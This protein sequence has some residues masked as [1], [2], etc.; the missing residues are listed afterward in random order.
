MRTLACALPALLATAV[1]AADGLPELNPVRPPARLAQLTG[2]IIVKLRAEARSGG[3]TAR[4][5]QQRLAAVVMRAGVR[6]AEARVI[7]ARLH[8]MQPADGSLQEILARL[9]A[10][11]EVEYAEAEQRRYPHGV[12]QAA[13]PDDPLYATLQWYLQSPTGSTPAAIDAAGGWN[14]STG[15]SDLVIADIDTGVRYDHPDLLDAAAGGRLL[16]GYCFISD[17][18]VSNGGGC[19][20]GEVSEEE[21]SDP[22]DWVTEADL[23]Q[24]QCA[25]AKA[26]NSS[27][28]GTRT[29]SLLGALTNNGLGIAGVTW[30][31]QILPVRALGRCGGSDA[32]IASA[33]LW[34]GGIS[35]TGAPPNPYPAKIINMSL[36]AAGVCPQVYQDVLAQLAAHGVLVVASAGNGGAAVEAPASCPG[37]AAVAGLRHAGTKTGYSNLG[38]EVIISAPSGNC[39]TGV[40]SAQTPCQ[41]PISSATNAGTTTPAPYTGVSADGV[42]TDRISSLNLGTSFA[43]PLVAGIGALMAA[44]NPQLS[45]CRLIARLQEG[46]APFPQ[47]SGPL[48]ACGTPG[49]AAPR[50]ECACTPT[51]CGAGMVSAPGALRAAL[52]PAAVIDAPSGY[53]SGQVIKLSGTASIA[54]HG[55]TLIAHAWSQVS[56]TPLQLQGAAS[57]A[58]TVRVPG[59]GLPVLRLSVTDSDGAVDSAEVTIGPGAVTVLPPAAPAPS[60]ACTARAQIG[61]CPAQ[62]S[63]QAG[64]GQV[65]FTADVAGASDTAVTWEVNGM[66]GGSAMAG[67]ISSLG[68][69]TPPATAPV[70]P[71]TVTAVLASDGTVSASAQV[72]VTA[73]AGGGG[74]LDWGTLG[75]GVFLAAL[76]LRRR[77]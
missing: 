51:T 36:G 58:V 22:G 50:A 64:G 30:Q 60:G 41:Y 32:D 28:H 44:V 71:V 2:R 38:P 43:A 69:Y 19:L 74:A 21:A 56:G 73:P 45:S 13:A 68:V 35:V 63:L 26:A 52:R 61:V 66:P 40:I 4:T 48:P 18:F 67:T 14:I 24:P 11:P 34:A 8:V 15:S 42:F 17:P 75:V 57:A 27:W 70:Q 37:V 29:A 5:G 23:G 25:E 31:T 7:T 54:A 49:E 47:G 39:V 16:P 6:A 33:M 72:M 55:R 9:T 46:A 20:G 76:R 62:A 53:T 3:G 65:A 12:L 59:C 10:D 77:P 1:L